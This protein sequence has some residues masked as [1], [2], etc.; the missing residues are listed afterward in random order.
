MYVCEKIFQDSRAPSCHS[1]NLFQWIAPQLGVIE[2]VKVTKEH[3][4]SVWMFF[5]DLVD[6][7]NNVVGANK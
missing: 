1:D 4:T 2:I 6:R 7:R 3:Y 5:H